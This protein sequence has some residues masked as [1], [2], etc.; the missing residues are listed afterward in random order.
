MLEFPAN[1]KISEKIRDF[2][3]G[4]AKIGSKEHLQSFTNVFSDRMFFAPHHR[5][6]KD[7]AKLAPTY[8]YFYSYQSKH[9]LTPLLTASHDGRFGPTMNFVV[10][11]FTRWF[12]T[13]V[14]RMEIP[15]LGVC[16]GVLKYKH[17]LLKTS[18]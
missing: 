12:K 14:L 15:P 7:Y 18:Y 13:T 9:S 17:I 11:M 5:F 10:N 4:T 2:Y 1:E 3:F 6:V 8:S 16:H